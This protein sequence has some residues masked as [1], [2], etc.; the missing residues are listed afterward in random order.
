MNFKTGRQRDNVEIF[1]AFANR[2]G[3]KFLQLSVSRMKHADKSL[4]C[5]EILFGRVAVFVSRAHEQ[6]AWE[7]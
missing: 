3:G 4:N 1:I 2:I 7:R 5:S 6:R